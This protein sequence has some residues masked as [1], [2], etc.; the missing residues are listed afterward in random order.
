MI[1]GLPASSYGRSQKGCQAGLSAD[2]AAGARRGAQTLG[3]RH[4]A[5]CHSADK[6]S[7]GTVGI[8]FARQATPK[9]ITKERP[10]APSAAAKKEARKAGS[11]QSKLMDTETANSPSPDR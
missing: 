2:Q 6:K 4:G 8:L 11:E 7:P 1:L 5:G 10:L 9:F 3:C